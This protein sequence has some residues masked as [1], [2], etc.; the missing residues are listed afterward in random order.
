[1]KFPKEMSPYQVNGKHIP[2]SRLLEFE[3]SSSYLQDSE[4]IRENFGKDGYLFFRDFIPKDFV[5]KAKN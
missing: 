1:M 4:R 3:D 5:N 2:W